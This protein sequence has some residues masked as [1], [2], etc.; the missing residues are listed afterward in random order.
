MTGREAGRGGGRGRG[1]GEGEGAT[2]LGVDQ[3]GGAAAGRARATD[4]MLV[5][6]SCVT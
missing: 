3:E 1:L 5:V 4:F 6:S 2:D